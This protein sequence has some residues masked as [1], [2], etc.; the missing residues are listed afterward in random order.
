MDSNV[1]VR[2]H[3]GLGNQLYSIAAAYNVACKTN[4]NL[5][6]TTPVK[7]DSRDFPFGFPTSYNLNL[8]NF[9]FSSKCRIVNESYV[10]SLLTNC[11]IT[12]SPESQ[13]IKYKSAQDILDLENLLMGSQERI[14]L[15]QGNFESHKIAFQAFQ[16]GFPSILFP[17]KLRGVYQVALSSL[18][19]SK[20]LGIHLRFGDFESWHDG[21]YLL[22]IDYY[23][24]AINM[25]LSDYEVSDIIIFSDDIE[26]AQKLLGKFYSKFKIKNFSSLKVIEQFLLLSKCSYLITSNS[27]FS[28]WAAYLSNANKIITPK[29]NP[30][31]PQWESLSF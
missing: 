12:K 31:Y 11:R 29:I 4:L 23:R 17:R 7:F 6:V 8:G 10:K 16:N 24:M 22:D 5:L 26:K 27:T 19:H 14:H 9:E 13:V 3:G 2:L 25:I 18:N 28:H 15:L 1:V 30:F 21:N 20:A